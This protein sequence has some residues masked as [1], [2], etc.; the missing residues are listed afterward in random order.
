[1]SPATPTNGRHVEIESLTS[2]ELQLAFFLNL[3]HLLINHSYLLLG[4][5]PSK[6]SWLSYYTT[7]AYHVG[8]ELF[9]L[10]GLEHCVLRAQMSVPSSIIGG[11]V[12]PT[13][14]YACALS[15]VETRLNFNLNCGS[16][17]SPPSVPLYRPEAIDAQL[18]AVTRTFLTEHASVGADG[19]LTVPS[20][21]QLFPRD[22]GNQG[23]KASPGEIA[24]YVAARLDP[25]HNDVPI[26]D[27]LRQQT[28]AIRYAPFEFRCRTLRLLPDEA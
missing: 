12:I 1:M 15:F 6:F 24:R 7:I 3:Y 9:S 25:A 8:D 19:R 28:P 16:F 4:P 11:L 10:A 5:P 18:D 14:R 26:V 20:V 17:S 2:R 23:A 13:S 21:F 27:L 22:F